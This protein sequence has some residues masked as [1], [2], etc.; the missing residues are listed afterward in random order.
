MK[1]KWTE[2]ITKAEIPRR[3]RERR[4]IMNTLRRRRGRF[5]GHILRHNI[6]LKTVLEEEISRNNYRGRI[7]MEYIGQIMKDM[8]TK[9]SYTW[10]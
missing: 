10:Q 6:V 3:V 8:K 1:I 2:R 9:S 7:R 5:I 4:N